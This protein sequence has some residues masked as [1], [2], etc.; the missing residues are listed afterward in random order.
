M[1]PKI[2]WSMAFVVLVIALCLLKPNAGRIFPGIFY[3]A[4]AIGI[5]LVNV[6]TDPQSTVRMGEASLIGLPGTSLFLLLITP[7]GYIQIP[8]LGI[9]LVQLYRARRDFDRTFWE[10]LAAAVRNRK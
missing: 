6:F 10:I 7:F 5:N 3:L 1:D 9:A 8:W 2:L 4:M